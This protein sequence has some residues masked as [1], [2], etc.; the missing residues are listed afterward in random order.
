MKNPTHPQIYT[1]TISTIILTIQCNITEPKKEAKLPLETLALT[2]LGAAT[3][4]T[5]SA[6]PSEES[7]GSCVA[8]TGSNNSALCSLTEG[9]IG[10][11]AASNA[12]LLQKQATVTLTNSNSDFTLGVPY[13]TR[14]TSHLENSF[15]VLPVTNVGSQDYCSVTIQG[16]VLKS[17]DGAT[18]SKSGLD[19][20]YATG[21]NHISTVILGFYDNTCLIAG[22]TG[23]FLGIELSLYSDIAEIAVDRIEATATTVSDDLVSR[24]IPQAIAFNTS[25]HELSMTVQNESSA[26][27]ELSASFN[28]YILLDADGLPLLWGFFLGLS[29][30]TDHSIAAG[31]SLD[32]D[33][34]SA[35]LYAG[36]AVEVIGFLAF[37]DGAS[38]DVLREG[39]ER[40]LL[41]R[42]RVL[43]DMGRK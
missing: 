16:I 12:D 28:K 24:V 34:Q 20:A 21:S 36:S 14:A 25:T 15:W 3:T 30:N 19:Y 23:Y 11:G 17:A 1:I 4:P 32:I 39:Y 10:L 13:I 37:G 35:G 8:R 41:E 33:D 9:T 5:P 26:T 6:D 42:Y 38:S 40:D 43:L 31:A 27:K 22:E 7:T 2:S 29:P 18:L